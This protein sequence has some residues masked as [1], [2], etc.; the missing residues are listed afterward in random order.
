M[1][2]YEYRCRQCRRTFEKI[3][4]FS[5]P[6]EE[7]CPACGGP[8]ERLVSPSAFQFKGS[9]WYVTDYPRKG[10]PASPSTSESAAASGNGQDKKAEKTETAAKPPETKKSPKA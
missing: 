2:L 9:G 5:D 6:P 1:P 7:T 3:Q 8:V 4:K 10:A